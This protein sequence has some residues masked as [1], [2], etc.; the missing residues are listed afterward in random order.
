MR[1]AVLRQPLQPLQIEDLELEAP[2]AGELRVRVEAAGVCHSD[3]HYMQGHITCPL[4]VVLGHE[5]AGIVEETGPGSTGDI[6]VGDRVAFMWRPRCGKCTA[7]IAGNPILCV[8]ARVQ[9]STGGLPDGTT[10]L[11]AGDAAVHHFLGVSCFAEQ[12]VVSERSVVKVPADVPPEIA[13]IAGCAVVTGVGALL[14]VVRGVAGHPVV[15]FGAG[16]VGL[17]AVLGA[18][19][20][21]ADPIAVVD[22]D[23]AR[24]ALATELGATD[25]VDGS[26][27]DVREKLSAIAPDGFDWAIEAVGLPSTLEQAF[28]SLGAGG[29]VVALGLAPADSGF[30]VPINQLVQR[31]KRIVGSLYGSANPLIDI[32]RI[33]RLY[34]SGR[35]PLQRLL[36]ER[37]PLSDINAAYDRLAHGGIGRMIVVPSE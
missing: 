23:A 35:L 8:T 18:Q 37:F 22:V 33:F 3:Y 1:A 15:I 9:A 20:V 28:A 30:Q 32:P 2:H 31:Q 25:S 13:A 7:C 19:L 6:A 14:N 27:L 21:G 34:S 24:L 12:V 10:R 36:G 17:S 4:P 5:G 11:R 29:T 16:G 26:E